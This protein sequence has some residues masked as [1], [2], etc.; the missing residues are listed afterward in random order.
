MTIKKN[1]LITVAIAFILMVSIIFTGCSS[2]ESDIVAK[3]NGE[4]ITKTQLDDNFA[5]Q[6]KMIENQY[7]TDVWTQEMGDGRLFEDVF[8]EKVLEG[9]VQEAILV[10]EAKEQGIEVT[11]E[12]VNTEIENLKE[13]NG[14]E[15][16]FNKSLEN[17]GITIDYLKDALRKEMIISQYQEKYM[18]DL[19]VSDAEAEEQFNANKDNYI[20][21]KVRHILVNTEEEA[22][23]IISQLNDGSDF[24]E[25]AKENSIDPG[26]A[27]Q[28]GMYDYF[29]KGTMVPE[30]EEV[31]FSLEPGKVSEPV[32]TDYGYHIIK[33]EDRR[34][35][36]DDLKESVV[37]DIKYQR[38][39]E[40]VEKLSDDADVE[41]FLDEK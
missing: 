21:A 12:E 25:L 4:E 27:S 29:T 15:E 10:Q 31:A 16:N 28:G 9:L 30:F 19:E 40:N 14:G 32:K 38:F 17:S 20:Q 34:E 2:N 8:K 36:F 3:V 18:G 26:S 35:T 39:S 22:Q 1:R 13:A 37:D 33:V 24:A 23:D 11:D 5:M 6:R 41:T 7:G